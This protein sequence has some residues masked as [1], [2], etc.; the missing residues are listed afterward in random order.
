M[1][2]LRDIDELDDARAMIFYLCE[3][4]TTRMRK[5][6]VRGTGVSVNLRSSNLKHIT[7]QKKLKVPTYATSE[8]A[9]C[10]F[11]LVVANKSSMPLRTVT[12]SVYGL[13]PY[14]GYVQTSMFDDKPNEKEE[15]LERAVDEIR[16]KYG[17]K[18]ISRA[19][20][21]GKDFIYDKTDAEDFLPF[22][23]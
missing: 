5:Y 7:R 21:L 6:K 16:A 9:A 3:M 2:A 22:Q 8:I 13:I 17:K 12:V 19:I 18:S 14:G 15:S 10:A 1:T 23:R 11:S 20:V 4:I